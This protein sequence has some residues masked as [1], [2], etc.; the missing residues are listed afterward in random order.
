MKFPKTSS[1][2]IAKERLYQMQENA[3][4]KLL[5]GQLD[6]FRKEVRKLSEKYIDGF[7]DEYELR[8]LIQPKEKRV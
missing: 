1:C 2:R 3:H 6:E 7:S 4:T 5:G 8:I